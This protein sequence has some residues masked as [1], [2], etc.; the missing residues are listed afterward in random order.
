MSMT[1]GLADMI[2][3]DTKEI[4]QITFNPTFDGF[5]MFNSD[6]SQLV[7]ASNRYNANPGDTNIFVAD[8][9][10]TQN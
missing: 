4:E 7:W 3:I 10:D 2:D 1:Y 5:P 6:G 9:V 8:W